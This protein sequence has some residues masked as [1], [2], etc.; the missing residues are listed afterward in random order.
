MWYAKIKIKLYAFRLIGGLE[1]TNLYA[2][3]IDLYFIVR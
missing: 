3:K 2:K 1:G